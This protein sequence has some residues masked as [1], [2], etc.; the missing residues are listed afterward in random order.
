MP[1]K[2]NKNVHMI[3]CRKPE[4]EEFSF[5]PPKIFHGRV[6]AITEFDKTF[7]Q[8]DSFEETCRKEYC[9]QTGQ[10]LFFVT[11]AGFRWQ[12]YLDLEPND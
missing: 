9:D 3:V 4:S 2:K 8:C 6:E 1:K 10:L 11:S 5:W 7:I 12:L